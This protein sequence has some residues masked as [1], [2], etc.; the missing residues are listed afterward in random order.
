MERFA[1]LLI[2]AIFCLGAIYPLGTVAQ[3]SPTATNIYSTNDAALDNFQ[4]GA[5]LLGIGLPL[6][7]QVALR[8]SL[9]IV[10]EEGIVRQIESQ[11]S[12]RELRERLQ[13]TAQNSRIAREQPLAQ[14][15]T[16]NELEFRYF[17]WV[18]GEGLLERGFTINLA[19]PNLDL[20]SDPRILDLERALAGNHT[21]NATTG[22]SNLRIRLTSPLQRGLR[23]IQLGG[24]ALGTLP[25]GIGGTNI[26]NGAVYSTKPQDQS[27]QICAVSSQCQERSSLARIL[28]AAAFAA[29]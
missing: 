5:V 19:D 15:R 2:R 7:A 25:I 20:A 8:R 9:G 4:Q 14:L 6:S 1:A 10:H 28:D 12:P 24:A 11:L 21:G 16:T 3:T 23:I 17:H 29:Q 22:P 18:P 13:A 27:K 26:F